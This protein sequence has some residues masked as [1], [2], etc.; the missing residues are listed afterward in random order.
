M[1]MIIKQQ[2]QED[3]HGLSGSPIHIP[4]VLLRPLLNQKWSKFHRIS[5][6][7]LHP[8]YSVEIILQELL[9]TFPFISILALQDVMSPCRGV[10]GENDDSRPISGYIW[11]VTKR[12]QVE[13]TAQDLREVEKPHSQT[14]SVWSVQ[15]ILHK[16]L[17]AFPFSSILSLQHVMVTIS[18]FYSI[19]VDIS[20]YAIMSD[21][22]SDW[23][24]GV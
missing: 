21:M 10:V 6:F 3:V 22:Y 23:L 12:S 24:M 19:H 9:R 17:Q 13:R 20:S 7:K 5:N 14:D 1:W 2:Q 16:H 15:T 11:Q 4:Q 8:F 18:N